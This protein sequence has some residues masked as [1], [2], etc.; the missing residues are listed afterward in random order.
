MARLK[1]KTQ[2]SKDQSK[3]QELLGILAT[4]GIYVTRIIAANDGF[5]ILAQNEE[6]MDKVFDKIID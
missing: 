2:N 4:N 6:E 3:R 1:I 5:I